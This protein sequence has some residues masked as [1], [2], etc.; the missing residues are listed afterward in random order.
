MGKKL[1][2]VALPL[3]IINDASAFDK[4]PLA[5][6][7]AK[8]IHYYPAR[9]PF[10]AARSVL[11]A[12]LIDDPSSNVI[13]FPDEKS[14]E[15]E[16]ARLFS[17]IRDLCKNKKHIN[18]I[19]FK[20]AFDEIKKACSNK[21][22]TVHDPF[23]GGGAVPLEG[24]RL[25]LKAI[26]ADLNPISVL[27]NKANIELLP[28]YILSSPINPESKK[29]EGLIEWENGQG[30]ESDIKY[31]GKIISK[32]IESKLV[33]CFPR[34]NFNGRDYKVQLYIWV[35]TIKCSNPACGCEMPLVKSFALRSKKP[36]K[37]YF[38][39]IFENLQGKIILSGFSILETN[40]G[41]GTIKRNKAFCANCNEAITLDYIKS[42]GQNS[43]MSKRLAAILIDVGRGSEFIAATLQDENIA[44]NIPDTWSPNYELS[45]HP[46]YMSPP[47]FGFTKFNDLFLNR[48]LYTISTISD[49]IHKINKELVNNG[50]LDHANLL[51]LYLFFALD[52][53]VGY[54]TSLS[55]WDN[56]REQHKDLFAATRYSMTW[57]F[58]EPNP[59]SEKGISWLYFVNKVAEGAG[60][61]LN[62]LCKPGIVLQKNAEVSDPS[63]QNLL[64]STDPPYY[65]N[66]PYADLMDFFYVW[67]KRNLEPYFPHLTKTLLTPK[68]EELVANEFRFDGD[69]E[70]A[71]EH[72]ES[73]FKRA[74]TVLKEAMDERFPM[75]IYYAFKQ[76]EVED[77]SEDDESNPNDITLTTGWE[78]ILEAVV[79]SGFQITATW[80]LRASQKWRLRAIGSNALASYIVMVCRKRD[81]KAI[82][83]TRRQ[84]I[85]E[86]K[87]ELPRA[88]EVLQRSNLAPVDLAQAALGPGM[89]IYSK[90]TEILEQD[91]SKMRVRTALTLIN[92]VLDEILTEQEED[93]DAETRWALAWFEQY[94]TSKQPYGDAESLCRAKGTAVNALAD[95]GIISA[96]GGFVKLF[97]REE[98]PA[99]WDP[100]T[101]RKTVVWEIAQH[102]IKH[103]Q[104]KGELGAARLYKSLGSKA[105]VA[106]ELAY[107]LFTISEKKGWAQEAQ[108]YNSLVLSWNQIV[109]ESYNIKDPIGTQGKL[110]F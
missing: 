19:A 49:E 1:I 29:Q 25:G 57:D 7:H 26:A 105:D 52:R 27:L 84:Y 51:T 5:G 90:Y 54:A 28:K 99:N 109:T 48:Q 9:L 59:F 92:K 13:K 70:K 106:R 18:S 36:P 12:S 24:M 102:L 35:R 17:L 33:D 31:Y 47:R 78:T 45:T 43:R 85:Q 23:S 4:S 80:P 10:P 86:L 38:K 91:G 81:D 101:D 108:A 103:L 107:R 22:P 83:I 62:P 41:P 82:S 30:V 95:S 89:G 40:P 58:P 53:Y 14:Q 15:L 63:L 3:D 96:G 64:V 56:T 77:A 32:R 16:R 68:A 67:M 98:L 104:E 94:G 79:Q 87:R 50:D 110:E 44:T 37:K 20:T 73:G 11:F 88:L 72:F 65:N 61:T 76:E 93:F 8:D 55:R 97:A 6:T 74:F 2:E 60:A 69:K 71:K 66:I 75:S 100:A 34:V 46:Q 39:P 42:E 21:M